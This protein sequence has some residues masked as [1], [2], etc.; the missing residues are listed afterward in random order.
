MI[1]WLSQSELS[2]VFYRFIYRII[3]NYYLVNLFYKFSYWCVKMICFWDRME[4]QIRGFY[5]CDSR[6]GLGSHT[7]VLDMRQSSQNFGGNRQVGLNATKL[8]FCFLSFCYL[9]LVVKFVI[10]D[11][12]SSLFVACISSVSQC[13]D[14][15]EGSVDTHRFFYP[16]WKIPVNFL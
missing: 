13:F 7:A 9:F 15:V 12:R 16:C 4:R 1:S 2:V 11:P 5:T 14:S 10:S 8:Y 6:L 3:Q